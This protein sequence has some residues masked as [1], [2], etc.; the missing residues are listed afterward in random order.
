ML[1]AAGK[2]FRPKE[3]LLLSGV[4]AKVRNDPS[5]CRLVELYDRQL[6]YYTVRLILSQNTE[7][8]DVS[9]RI[10]FDFD[11]IFDC[12]RGSN[13]DENK[14]RTGIF[15]GIKFERGEEY[16]AFY[17]DDSSQVKAW[18]DVLA[19]KLNQRGFHELL[20]P[21]K[22]IGKGNFASVYL[23]VRLEDEKK[24]AIKAFSKQATYAE[25]KG[26]ESLINEIELMRKFSH[27][28][29]MRLF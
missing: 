7:K 28:N 10:V 20:K 17:S 6:V 16:A 2:N 21:I 8:K 11:L 27:K 15:Y 4:F 19:T 9:K 5:S 18:R 23:A 26:K 13:E 1:E 22:K 24:F 12:L 14:R 29:I 3:E 25:E